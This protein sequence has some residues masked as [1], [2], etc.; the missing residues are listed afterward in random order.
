[1]I[2][3][4]RLDFCYRNEPQVHVPDPVEHAVQ[5]G[6]IRELAVESGRAVALAGDGQVVEPLGPLAVQ[7]PLDLD[8]LDRWG[9]AIL[10][11]IHESSL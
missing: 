8:L 4:V 7:V 1:M 11:F 6:L 10:S 5:D 2:A 3:R 9:E